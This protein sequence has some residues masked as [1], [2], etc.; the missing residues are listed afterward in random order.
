MAEVHAK[1][2]NP[3]LKVFR[4]PHAL[5][6]LLVDHYDEATGISTILELEMPEEQ[7]DAWSKA[8]RTPS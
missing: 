1:L 3:N 4:G 7:A 8:L 6:V 2:V 5:V